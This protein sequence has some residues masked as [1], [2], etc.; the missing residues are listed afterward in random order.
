MDIVF[1]SKKI[2]QKIE[3]LGQA[4]ESILSFAVQRASAIANYDKELAITI[5]KLRMGEM[6]E[7]NGVLVKEA[8]IS[9]IEK[10]AKGI[11]YNARLRLEKAEGLYRATQTNMRALEAELNGLQTLNRT[12]S[13][14]V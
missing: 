2:T 7:I 12:L 10:L 6:Q 5:V 1:I 9:L 4:R 8:S 14:E 3:A 13:E 11:C